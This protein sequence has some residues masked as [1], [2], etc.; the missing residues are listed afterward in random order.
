MLHN[1]CN[2]YNPDLNWWMDGEY[3]LLAFIWYE[4]VV[5]WTGQ[6]LQGNVL[7]CTRP[8]ANVRVLT[9]NDTYNL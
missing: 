3:I 2:I 7:K 4:F 1:T 8:N 9:P 6:Y 5:N